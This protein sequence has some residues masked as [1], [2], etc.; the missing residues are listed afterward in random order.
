MVDCSARSLDH[1]P[2]DMAFTAETLPHL[3]VG[4]SYFVY[5]RRLWLVAKWLKN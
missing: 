5:S 3:Y 4:L 1:G 2:S